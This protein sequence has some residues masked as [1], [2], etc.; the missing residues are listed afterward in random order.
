MPNQ[1]IDIPNMK[2]CMEGRLNLGRILGSCN[3][4]AFPTLQLNSGYNIRTRLLIQSVKQTIGF[5]KIQNLSSISKLMGIMSLMGQIALS[6]EHVLNGSQT[7]LL[8]P[9]HPPDIPSRPRRCR[10]LHFQFPVSPL[11]FAPSTLSPNL[12]LLTSLC[13]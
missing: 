7:T 9:P 8:L 12:S 11:S 3:W 5:L 1:T 6:A 13:S 2:T 10:Y 4:M